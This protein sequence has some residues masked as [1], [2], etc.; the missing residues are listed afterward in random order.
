MKRQTLTRPVSSSKMMK[1]L[2]LSA[3]R[4]L[5]EMLSVEPALG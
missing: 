4:S 5:V 1:K 2:D 3:L